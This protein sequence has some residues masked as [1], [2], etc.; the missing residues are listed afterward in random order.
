MNKV[1][2]RIIICL[3]SVMLF[4]SLAACGPEEEKKATVT[5]SR[6][7]N[8]TPKDLRGIIKISGYRSGKYDESIMDFI[9]QVALDYSG[10]DVEYDDNCTEEEYFATLDERIAS[11]DIGDI[12]LVRDTDLATYAE[13]NYLLDLTDYAADFY[14]YSNSSYTKMNISDEVFPAAYSS[15]QYQGRLYMVPAEYNHKFVFLNYTLLEKAGIETVPNDK[16]TWEDFKGYA[17][18]VTAAGGKI[19]MDYTD[20]AVWGAFINGMGGSVFALNEDGTPNP[21]KVSLTDDATLSGLNELLGFVKSNNVQTELGNTDLAEVGIAVIDRSEMGLWQ[22]TAEEEYF[23]WSLIDFDW[24]FM[25]FPRFA[26]HSVGAHTVGFAVKNTADSDE[27][28]KELCAKVA[29]YMLFDLPAEAYTGDGEVV[30]ANIRVS[31]MKF[32]RE[33]PVKGKN[34]S[35]FTNYYASDFSASLTAVMNLNAAKQITVGD[36]LMQ[37]KSG[38]D[39]TGLLRTIESAAN[40]ALN[41]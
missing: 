10:L 27:E 28:H 13:K 40:S 20:Y 37:A 1:F 24:D 4:V 17:S 23:D 3:L 22:N 31:D 15:S 11:G 2:R 19:V 33:Y 35:V 6:T 41:G 30:P 29:L 8:P 7:A 32:W 9:A 34:T 14:D 39:I 21:S 18:A 12:Y 25:H 26:T 36:A 16:W 5:A 38:A